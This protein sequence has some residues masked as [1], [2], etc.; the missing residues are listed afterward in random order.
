MPH[1]FDPQPR[2][3]SRPTQIEGEVAGIPLTLWT[4]AQVFSQQRIDPGSRLLA[5]SAKVPAQAHILDL[6]AGYGVV[7]IALA[8]RFQDATVI[9]SE[10]NQRAVELARRNAAPLGARVQVRQGDG[11]STVAGER[12]D[13]ICL[14]PPIRAG[15]EVYYPWLSACATHL[16][17]GG[18]LYV[19]VQRK[20]GSESLGRRL[21][22]I[23]PTCSVIAKQGGYHVW[24]AS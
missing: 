12:F 4:D 16:K 15:K 6:A 17:P 5:E 18:R 21:A 8:M 2:A 20:Q 9:L 24:C 3:P 10:L 14:N 22:E 19:V 11:L 7:G 13:V 1:Y 23:F